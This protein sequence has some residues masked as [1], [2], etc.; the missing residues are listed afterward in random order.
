MSELQLIKWFLTF[1]KFLTN[2]VWPFNVLITLLLSH[3][4]IVLSPDN[5][6]YDVISSFNG[7]IL[8]IQFLCGVLIMVIG[9]DL[10]WLI[11]IIGY[12]Y[13]FSG[14]FISIFGSIWAGMFGLGFRLSANLVSSY[15]FSSIMFD[16]VL[17]LLINLVSYC[18]FSY[19]SSMKFSLLL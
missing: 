1:I 11:S 14:S 6:A 4:I 18:S 12:Y 9:Y 3:I 16:L 13:Y 17:K 15:P 8:H 7:I 10:I 5:V 2:D 19:I